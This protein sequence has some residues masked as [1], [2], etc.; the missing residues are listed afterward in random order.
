MDLTLFDPHMRQFRAP[1]LARCLQGMAEGV[2][3][4]G[5]DEKIVLG[6]KWMIERNSE[7][8]GWLID[9]YYPTLS[10]ASLC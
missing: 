1:E 7:S 10:N 2:N 3:A 8:L 4:K 9:R 6:V 5:L